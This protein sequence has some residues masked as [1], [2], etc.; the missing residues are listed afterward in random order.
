MLTH[1]NGLAELPPRPAPG[2]AAAHQRERERLRRELLRRLVD[3]ELHR[4]S[5]RGA[6]R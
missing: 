3:R 2:V 4:R 5:L 6:F 1:H